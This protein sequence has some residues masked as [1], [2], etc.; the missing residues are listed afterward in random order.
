MNNAIHNVLLW[1]L[2]NLKHEKENEETKLRKLVA[3]ST[4]PAEVN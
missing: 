4:P 2:S 1:S 3:L